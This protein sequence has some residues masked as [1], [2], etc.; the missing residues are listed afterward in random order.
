MRFTTTRALQHSGD[1]QPPVSFTTALFQGLA[2]DGGLYVPETIEAW[3]DRELARLPRRTLTE[4][5]LRVLRPFTRGELDPAVLEAVVVE[6]LVGD[7]PQP[8]AKASPA[9]PSMPRASRRF[10][11]FFVRVLFMPQ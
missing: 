11:F 10:T 3:P 4:I 2:A 8:A 9:A 6:A 7:D 1:E 5:A